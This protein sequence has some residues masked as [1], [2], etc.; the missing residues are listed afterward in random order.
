MKAAASPLPHSHLCL[1]TRLLSFEAST[2]SKML[3][4]I[5]NDFSQTN[6]LAIVYLC[7]LRH[8]SPAIFQVIHTMHMCESHALV[9]KVTFACV[10]D[11]VA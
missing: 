4:E 7:I 6:Y 5:F 2:G 1:W 9:G 10:R 3:A 8:W 11:R